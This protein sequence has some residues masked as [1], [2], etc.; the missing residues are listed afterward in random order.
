MCFG[1]AWAIGLTPM[2]QQLELRTLDWRTAFRVY[3]QKAPDPRIAIVLYGD[4]TDGAS[5]V[6]QWPPDRSVHSELI[7]FIAVGQPTVIMYDVIVDASR[8][9][10]GDAKM[11]A[12]VQR[13]AKAGVKVVTAAVRSSRPGVPPLPGNAGPT[14]PLKNIEGNISQLLGDQDA[15]RPFP[16]LRAVSRYGFADTPQGRDGVQREIP[17]VVR[18]GQEVFPSLAL[19]TLMAY[20]DVPVEQVRLRLGDAAYLDTPART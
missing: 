4:E 17:V 10:D 6:L 16:L 9:G 15:I 14:Q 7:S 3:F 8:P 20:L 2:M 13:A 11:A 19:Q 18:I 1:A 5:P 12:E